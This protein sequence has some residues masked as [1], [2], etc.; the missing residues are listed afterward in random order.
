MIIVN[1]VRQYLEIQ[2]VLYIAQYA[3]YGINIKLFTSN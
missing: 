1:I 2:L 3:L